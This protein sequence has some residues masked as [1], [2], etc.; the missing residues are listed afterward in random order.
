[1]ASLNSLDTPFYAIQKKA[2][3]IPGDVGVELEIEGSMAHGTPAGHWS[4]KEEG[5]LRSGGEYVLSKPW[6]IKLLP[7]ALQDLQKAIDNSKPQNSIRCSTHIH[8]NVTSY[9]PRQV[10]YILLAYYLLEPILM[11][12]QPRKRWGNLFCLTMEH[13]ENIYLDLEWDLYNHKA[14]AFDTFTRDRNRYAALNLVSVKKFGSI[15]FRFLDAMTNCKDILAWSQMFHTLTQVASN[16]TPNRLF[17]TYDELSPAE[18]IRSLMG[19]NSDKYIL[20]K[21]PSDLN[22]NQLIHTN[23]DYMIELAQDLSFKKFQLPKMFWDADLYDP[24]QAKE[25]Y[26]VGELQEGDDWAAPPTPH[27]QVINTLQGQPWP[28]NMTAAQIQQMVANIAEHQPQPPQPTGWTGDIT[29]TG[30]VTAPPAAAHTWTI[31]D[32]VGAP[33]EFEPDD[34]A[35]TA[36]NHL[37]DPENF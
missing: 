22:L 35:T 20:D 16:L 32:D 9:T 34:F 29:P 5:S 27:P 15:E 30:A 19:P 10:W 11:R 7:E 3:P 12:T 37:D 14:Q 21:L 23:Y 31:F 13:A 33:P 2:K 24:T 8:V 4:F 26:A 25:M 18:F 17:K 1:M 36:P 28:P 6:P